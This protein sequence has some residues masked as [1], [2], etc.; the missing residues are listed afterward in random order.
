MKMEKSI[1]VIVNIFNYSNK[2]Y[3]INLKNQVNKY[4]KNLIKLKKKITFLEI[5]WIEIKNI[6]RICK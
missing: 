5:N 6:L 3:Q 2:L 1:Q 4:F